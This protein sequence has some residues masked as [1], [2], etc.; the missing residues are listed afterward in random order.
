[1]RQS[2]IVLFVLLGVM[3]C[4][5]FLTGCG[6][7][8]KEQQETKQANEVP[9]LVC[10]KDGVRLYK[11]HDTTEGGTSYVYFTVPVGSTHWTTEDSEGNVTHH[12]VAGPQTGAPKKK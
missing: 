2:K 5:F 12:Q 10:E 8:T 3:V 11:I 6:S 9:I 7:R 1:M 4:L